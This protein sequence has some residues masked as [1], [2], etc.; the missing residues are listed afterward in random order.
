MCA[1]NTLRG[2]FLI[3]KAYLNG[4]LFFLWPRQDYR[5]IL[6]RSKFRKKNSLLRKTFSISICFW[7]W[8]Y[9]TPKMKKSPAF[10][11]E[12]FFLRDLARIQ[13]WNLLSRNQM[14]YSVAP[15]GLFWSSGAR[16][17]T[18]SISGATRPFLCKDKLFIRIESSLSLNPLKNNIFELWEL[19][20]S[21]LWSW[22]HLF[23]PKTRR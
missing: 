10:H 20:S 12:L 3:K 18:H 22:V 14:R 5:M 21:F 7:K 23:S 2:V 19:L 15:R 1:F 13:T 6:S 11:A 16:L 9:N 17:H 8:N 4:R